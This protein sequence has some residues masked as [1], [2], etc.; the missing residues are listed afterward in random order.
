MILVKRIFRRNTKKFRSL[1]EKNLEKENKFTLGNTLIALGVLIFM[2]LSYYWTNR[3]VIEAGF[4]VH[5]AEKISNT[6]G[7]ENYL[8]GITINNSGN[9]NLSIIRAFAFAT[10]YEY[11]VP[12]MALLQREVFDDVKERE[13]KAGQFKSLDI[14]ARLSKN[15][16]LGGFTKEKW[17]PLPFNAVSLPIKI[18]VILLTSDNKYLIATSQHLAITHKNGKSIKVDKNTN[19][20]TFEELKEPLKDII[21]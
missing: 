17:S 13:I 5:S 7:N 4:I 21:Y 12:K 8:I 19:A 15:L 11:G 1:S 9:K 6:N 3:I 20:V 14:K 18:Q 2:V 16:I 10:G